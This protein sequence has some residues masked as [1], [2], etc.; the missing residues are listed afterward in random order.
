MINNY[1]GM[2]HDISKNLNE[3]M[4]FHPEIE[5]VFVLD[6][7]AKVKIKGTTYDMTSD[8]VIVINSGLMHQIESVDKTLICTVQFSCRLMASLLGR[9]DYFFVCCSV[10]DRMKSY[11]ELRSIFREIVYQTLQEKRRSECIIRSMMYRLLDQLIEYFLVDESQDTGDITSEDARMQMIVQYVNQNYEEN[12]SLSTLAEKMFTSSSTLSRFFKKQTG[13]YF[14]EYVNRIRLR[15]AIENLIYSDKNITKVAVDSGFSNIS[16][17]NRLFKDTYGMS[18]SDYRKAHTVSE[19]ERKAE[20]EAE[21]DQIKEQ[22]E[23]NTGQRYKRNDLITAEVQMDTEKAEFCE[24]KWT[25]TINVGSVNQLLMANIQYHVLYLAENV[26]FQ[27]ARLWNV[28]SSRLMITDGVHI[29]NYNYDKIDIAL[30]FL[31]KNH[32]IP[33]LDLGIRPDTAVKSQGHPIFFDEEG[34]VFQSREAW[35]EAVRSLISHFVRRYG[36]EEVNTWIF[37]ICAD[38]VHSPETD[39]YRDNNYEYINAFEY[40]YRTV[41]SRLPQAMV[42]GPMS[43]MNKEPE[44]VRNFLLQCQK[45]GC[46]PDFVSFLLFPYSSAGNGKGNAYRRITYP[47]Y[48]QEQVRMMRELVNETGSNCKICISEWNNSVSN[49]NYLNDSCFRGA[50]IAK[51]ASEI[52]QYVDMVNPWMA[53]DWVSNYYDTIGIANGGGGLLTKDT[54]CKPVYFTMQFL[55]SMGDYL[56]G[57][58]D[59]CIV[60]KTE[61]NTYYVL[62]F[63]YKWYSAEYLAKE[64]NLEE[65]DRIDECFEDRRPVVFDLKLL[66][67]PDGRYIVKKRTVSPK[68]G[69]LLSEWRKF[70]YDPSLTARDVKY[71]RQICF[72]RLSMNR[73]EVKDG[74]LQVTQVLDAHEVT[75]IH[76]YESED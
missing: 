65:P 35:E 11:G 46:G 32:L 73:T 63:N 75:L 18:P 51:K 14:N 43:I 34:I 8:D 24:K 12:I 69:S 67:V 4:H 53:S 50:Y 44:F 47:E 68:E 31:V 38:N 71:V 42:G 26:G 17:F 33:F 49:R 58:S 28:F 72:P 39:C 59:N 61:Q 3:S 2:K 66:N 45:R 64:E 27:Y 48:E 23:L 21:L 10:R 1:T 6:G 20:E 37:E 40:L 15:A 76:I 30:D 16:V 57:C 52:G 36:K 41:K 74:I 5:V 7:R 13:I 9:D 29:G 25:K 60:T 62:C 22:L 54:I 19:N 56:I 55:E 70:H